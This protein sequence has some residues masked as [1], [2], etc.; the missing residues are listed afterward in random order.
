MIQTKSNNLNFIP[1]NKSN[2]KQYL[3][4]I[5]NSV[6]VFQMHGKCNTHGK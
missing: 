6:I 1:V 5:A 4:E 2:N 3:K